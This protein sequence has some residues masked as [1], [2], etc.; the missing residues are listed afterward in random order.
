MEWD[1]NS[2]LM[3]YGERWRT[4]RRHLHRAFHP[5]AVSAHFPAQAAKVGELVIHLRDKPGE[6]RTHIKQ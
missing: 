2:G 1:W 3:P 4:Q 6:F 5:G